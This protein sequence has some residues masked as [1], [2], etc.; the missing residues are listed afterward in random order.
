MLSKASIPL[1]VA[2]IGLSA[3]S[4]SGSDRSVA[5]QPDAS[6]TTPSNEA[7][8]KQYMA[9]LEKQSRDE[10]EAHKSNQAIMTR[11]EALLARQ[12]QFAERWEKILATWERQQAEYQKYL[13][14]LP[15]K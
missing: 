5:Q 14:T 2:V 11:S 7:I 3:C 6:G 8:A 1:F 13:D 10:E 15:K 4:A 12:E 9:D